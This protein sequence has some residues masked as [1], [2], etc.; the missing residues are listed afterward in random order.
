MVLFA[1]G[2]WALL[3]RT[4]PGPPQPFLKQRQHISKA[5][6]L[7][8]R[9]HPE[10]VGSGGCVCAYV[11]VCVRVCGYTLTPMQTRGDDTARSGGVQKQLNG[12]S[13]WL[14]EVEA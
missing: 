9:L 3:F 8:H 4:R 12:H 11:Y 7:I 2:V 6:S 10:R 5:G 14:K 1:L 13:L